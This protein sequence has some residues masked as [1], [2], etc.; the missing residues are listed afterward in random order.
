[1]L[2]KMDIGESFTKN[3]PIIDVRSP[4]EFEKGHIPGAH[5]IPLFSDQERA[6]V[7]TV[8]K[9]ESQEAAINLGYTYVTPKL[10][11]FVSQAFE[12]APQGK[13]IVHCWRGGMRSQAFGEHL[14]ANG[15]HEVNVVQGGYKAYR[16][17]VLHSFEVPRTLRV[18]GGFTGSGKTYILRELQNLG[19]HIIDLEGLAHHK[20]SAFGGIGQASQ[21]TVEQFE[22][23]LSFA[24]SKLDLDRPI[25]VEDESHNIGSVKIPRAFFQQ[26]RA[27]GLVFLEIP[28]K[29]RVKHLVAGYAR[30]GDANLI[31]GIRRISKRLGGL[32]TKEMLDLLAGKHYEEVAQMA[33]EYYDSYYLKSL[34]K[35]DGR[36]TLHIHLESTCHRENAQKILKLTLNER[37]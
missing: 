27:A 5:N 12:I 11:Y 31:E 23:D 28:I 16:N 36:S 10:D 18:L 25:W 17:G 8:Y 24:L 9:M 34:K 35:R 32:R 4:G 26:M 29:E 15:F 13:V 3:L 1:M 19:E 22:N 6:Q 30:S 14:A 37:H 7:G 20:G 33:L 21:P 2:Q